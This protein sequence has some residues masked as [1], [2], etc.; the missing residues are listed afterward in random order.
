MSRMS[1]S[2]PSDAIAKIENVLEEIITSLS[3]EEPLSINLK[4]KQKRNTLR[5]SPSITYSVRSHTFPGATPQEAWRFS[6]P[7]KSLTQ[8]FDV[9]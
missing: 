1:P 7:L 3:K 2:D 9:V 5:E 8:T 4:Y 6:E